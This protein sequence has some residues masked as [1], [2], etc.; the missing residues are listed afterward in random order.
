MFSKTIELFKCITFVLGMSLFIVVIISPLFVIDYF[1]KGHRCNVTYGRSYT[2]EFGLF[3]GC[4]V[5]LEDGHW[6]PSEMI[7][8]FNAKDNMVD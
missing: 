6:I 8:E 1:V 3:Q 2:V 4:M 7:R 5:K